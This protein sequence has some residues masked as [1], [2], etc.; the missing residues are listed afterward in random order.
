MFVGVVINYPTYRI[1]DPSFKQGN[2][3]SSRKIQRASHVHL[4]RE[5]GVLNKVTYWFPNENSTI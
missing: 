4:K 3:S 5:V 2:T 1:V